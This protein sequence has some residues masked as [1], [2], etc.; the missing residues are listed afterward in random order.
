M[1]SEHVLF[2][3]NIL[4][5]PLFIPVVSSDKLYCSV[6]SLGSK[7]VHVSPAAVK[8]SWS[9]R[10]R[11]LQQQQLKSKVLS[12]VARNQTKI[13]GIF[14]Q[15]H[16]RH[17]FFSCDSVFVMLTWVHSCRLL[18]SPSPL[19]VKLGVSNSSSQ[20][21]AGSRMERS[22]AGKRSFCTVCLLL[23]PKVD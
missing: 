7:D 21:S 15:V 19:C 2:V 16:W 12:Q 13:P 1:V 10:P 14:F 17:F 3:W 20:K 22:P 9:N 23:F 6:R 4:W 18:E 5:R 8:K 11:Y